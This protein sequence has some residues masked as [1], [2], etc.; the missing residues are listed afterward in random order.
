MKPG[1]YA[2]SLI[3]MH[4]DFS[5]NEEALAAHCQDLLHRGCQGVVLFGT[6]GEGP[7]FTIEERKKTL[8][9]LIQ[10]GIPPSSIVLAVLCCAMDDAVSLIRFAHEI[11]CNNILLAPPFYYKGE[12]EEGVIAYYR[13]V[14]KRAKNPQLQILLYHIPQFTN[15][16]ITVNIIKALKE[17]FPKTVIGLKES[18]GNL[19][20]TKEILAKFPGFLVFVGNE[21]QIPEAVR[22]GGSGS[23]CGIANLY[24]ELICSLYDSDKEIRKINTL[25]IDLRKYPLF[26]A[27][28]S[29]AESQ[30]G[31]DWHIMRPPFTPLSDDQRNAL[32]SA[33]QQYLE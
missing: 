9:H 25:L 32:Y 26:P 30:K 28:K 16:P 7:S 11:G 17:E 5:C 31:S 29:I 14:I 24:P 33:I 12:E 3:P 1:I 13:E 6:T 2:A 21:T 19:A 23:I 10:Q 18:E 15:V 8:K 27:I 4:D 20:L 22:L